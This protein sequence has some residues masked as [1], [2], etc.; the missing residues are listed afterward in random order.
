MSPK[1]GAP[2][3][4]LPY[5]VQLL[6]VIPMLLVWLLMIPLGFGTMIG[7]MEWSKSIHMVPNFHQTPLETCF[8]L[9]VSGGIATF[10]VILWA[11]F[12]VQ[13]EKFLGLRP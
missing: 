6:L 13:L 9:G 10:L 7:I 3:K 12:C 2:K 4:E 5:W 1:Q 8:W 11:N